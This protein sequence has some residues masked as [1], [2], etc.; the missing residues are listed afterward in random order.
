M[1]QVL[2]AITPDC[3]FLVADRRLTYGSG[4]RRGQVVSEDECKVVSLCHVNAIGYTGFAK[5]GNVA[6]NEWIACT[7]A[8][9][10]CHHA[11]QASEV[12]STSAHF[13]L[14]PL[15]QA[16]RRQAFLMCGWAPFGQ[17]RLVQPHISL[18]SNYHDAAIAPT[19]VARGSF[20]VNVRTLKLS[21]A[22]AAFA[23]G[24]PL[25]PSRETALLRSIR[26]AVHRK[27]GYAAVL[28]LLA[29][30]VF[31]TSATARTVGDRVQACCIPLASARSLFTTGAARLSGLRARH[32]RTTFS[33]FDREYNEY[34][35]FGPTFACGK[36]AFTDIVYTRSETGPE[37]STSFRAL[38]APTSEP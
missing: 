19:A 29:E 17:D 31:R 13:A 16:S 34:N 2:A 37:T 18:I 9:A 7:L 25:Q 24:E 12:L 1:T 6:T 11:A 26:R 30:E 23:I 27:N 4:A 38:R 14:P 22:A 32:D 15:P 10:D 5:L 36:Q 8:N 20:N 35:Q 33:Y 21:E 3:A 28:R